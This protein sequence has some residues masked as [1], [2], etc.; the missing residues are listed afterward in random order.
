MVPRGPIEAKRGP[1]GWG[2]AGTIL[3][4]LR[5]QV[6]FL[7][8]GG[9]SI[10]RVLGMVFRSR[11]AKGTVRQ[12]SADTPKPQ[13]ASTWKKTRLTCWRCLGNFHK[14]PYKINSRVS[15]LPQGRP[16]LGGR[17][18]RPKESKNG[19]WTQVCPSI[20]KRVPFASCYLMTFRV[21]YHVTDV[22]SELT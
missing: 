20:W 18:H 2:R 6:F 7:P 14:T 17:R 22:Q 10:A 21:G 11:V 19:S 8:L 15:L 13:Y 5:F 16:D 4:N 9:F 12:T 1:L 3:L